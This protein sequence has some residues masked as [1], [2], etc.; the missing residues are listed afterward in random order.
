MVAQNGGYI[1]MTRNQRGRHEEIELPR[2][3]IEKHRKIGIRVRTKLRIKG[4]EVKF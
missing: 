1:C 3:A 2:R 4:I